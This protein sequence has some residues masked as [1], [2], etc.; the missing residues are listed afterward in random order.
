[1]APTERLREDK[2]RMIIQEPELE[3]QDEQETVPN[4]QSMRDPEIE[5]LRRQVAALTEA[6]TRYQLNVHANG[7][8]S[9]ENHYENPLGRQPRA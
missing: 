4:Q 8:D 7:Y 5:A 3:I 2:L 1:M 6:M 9:D